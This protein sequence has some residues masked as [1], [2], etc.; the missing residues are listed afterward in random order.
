MTF[1]SF[2]KRQLVPDESPRFC[3]IS[4]VQTLLSRPIVP[5]AAALMKWPH[6][7]G[8][9]RALGRSFAYVHAIAVVLVVAIAFGLCCAFESAVNAAAADDALMSRYAARWGD[10]P[11][12]APIGRLLSAVAH[13]V[14]LFVASFLVLGVLLVEHRRWEPAPADH[15]TTWWKLLLYFARFQSALFVLSVATV[16]LA[17]SFGLVFF[18]GLVEQGTPTSLLPWQAWFAIAAAGV[19]VRSLSVTNGRFDEF[20]GKLTRS[21]SDAYRVRNQLWLFVAVFAN[22]IREKLCGGSFEAGV[23]AVANAYTPGGLGFER[24]LVRHLASAIE[25]YRREGLDTLTDPT[26]PEARHYTPAQREAF[27]ATFARLQDQYAFA[28]R[29]V[30]RLTARPLGHPIRLEGVTS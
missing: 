9:V 23:D 3:P 26:N 13:P 10:G 18:P 16:V 11:V 20:T 28:A 21:L 6:R 4:W 27:V 30:A 24:R 7:T 17:M 15:K 1:R 25:F 8:Q 12:L 2:V 29:W 14:V 22:G 5:S 19:V